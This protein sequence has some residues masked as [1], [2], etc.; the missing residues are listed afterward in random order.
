MVVSGDD[1][2]HYDAVRLDSFL[3]ANEGPMSYADDQTGEVKWTDKTGTAKEL[4]LGPHAISILR[5]Q[6]W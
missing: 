2:K 4:K 1:A 6:M 5:R 3:T